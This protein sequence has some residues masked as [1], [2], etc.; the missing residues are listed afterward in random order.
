MPTEAT[1]L[2]AALLIVWAAS[3]WAFGRFGDKDRNAPPARIS[4]DYIRGLNLVLSRRTDE[5]LE[6]FLQMAKVD[7][8]TLE[9]HF[10]L[11]HLFRRRGEVDRAI[12]VHQNLL[13]RPS[14][15]EEQRSQ[16]MF[17]LGEDYL[18]AG[19]FDRA[20][21]IFVDLCE[22]ESVGKQ[23]LERLIYIYEREQEWKKAIETH[24]RLEV[25][26]GEKSAQVAHYYCELAEQA[27]RDGDPTLARDYLKSTVRSESGALR[28]TLIRAQLAK[29]EKD[30]AQAL[31]LYEQLLSRDRTF[32]S[33]VFTDF[34]ACFEATGRLADFER[35]VE[36]L[37]SE[38]KQAANEVAYAA[39]VGGLTASPALV[40]CIER[41]VVGDEILGNLV[42]VEDLQSPN[43]ERR[44]AAFARIASAL[45]KLALSSAR[46]RCTNCGYSTQR[47][48]WHCPSCKLWE[49]IR[50]I[51]RL[52]IE[53]LV[54]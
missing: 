26:S 45:R 2:L 35:Y 39:I 7:E 44:A 6:L 14:L 43:A 8:E 21:K 49:S 53:S 30:Y 19:L 48:V 20:E 52:P 25:L 36:K 22:S 5:A 12:R 10:A 46:Y 23:A 9:T 47:F 11:G 4:A 42:N 1:F 51:Q 50:P 27:L 32:I 31:G 38:D 28:G 17:A 29:L 13:A 54:A 3:G 34:Y 41:F 15:T 33:E 16:A 24:R 40:K 37:I 18:G